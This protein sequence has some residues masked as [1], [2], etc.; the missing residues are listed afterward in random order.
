MV[1]ICRW[2]CFRQEER[3]LDAKVGKNTGFKKS[4]TANGRSTNQK[5]EI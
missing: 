2:I 5:R 4:M 1:L 3:K